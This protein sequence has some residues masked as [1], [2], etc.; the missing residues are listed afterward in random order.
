MASHLKRARP[1]F[2]N[3]WSSLPI[4]PSNLTLANTL[5]VGQS[6]LWHRHALPEGCGEVTEEYSRAIDFPPRVVCLRQSP[7][8]I[9]Y[10][11]IPATPAAL[12]ADDTRSWLE[13]YF[14]LTQYPDLTKLYQA[15]EERDPALFGKTALNAKAVGVRVLRQDPWECLVAYGVV[16]ASAADV[17]SFITSTNN[18]ITRIS[19]LL[20]KLSLT[21]SSPILSL[22]NPDGQGETVYHLFPRA[23]HIPLDNLESTLRNLG[24]GYR[25]AFI[26]S[27]LNSLRAVENVDEELARWRV[28]PLEETRERLLELKGVGRKVADCVQLMCMDEVGEVKGCTD[29]V[30]LSLVPIDTHLHAIAMRHPSFPSRLKGK[31]ISKAIYDDVQSFLAECWGPCAGWAQA[32]MFAKAVQGGAPARSAPNKVEILEVKAENVDLSDSMKR[33]SDDMQ[34]NGNVKR[35]RRASRDGRGKR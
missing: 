2:P 30:Q 10:T 18:H 20:H 17:F 13:D 5:P 19:S 31:R 35:A 9:Y 22:D 4:T 6:F 28:A 21:F 32:V 34:P 14:Q 12:T 29:V 26:T 3:G 27:T 8:H 25:A 7:T 16:S 33:A 15:W 23:E 1:P 24:F 11:A